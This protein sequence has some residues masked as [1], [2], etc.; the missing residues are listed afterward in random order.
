MELI[1]ISA[2][3]PE[4]VYDFYARASLERKREGDRVTPDMLDFMRVCLEHIRA[5]ID[6]PPVFVVT[7]HYRLRLIAGDSYEL[8]TLVMLEPTVDGITVSYLLTDSEAPWH[9]ARVSGLA[10]TPTMAAEM[11]RVSLA[12]NANARSTDSSRNHG[13]DT[14]GSVSRF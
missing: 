13:M 1:R 8:P 4:S 7:S 10:T 12:R 5:A 9:N 3:S 2:Q 6:L 14:K 11:V